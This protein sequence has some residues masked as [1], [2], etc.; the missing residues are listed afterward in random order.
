MDNKEKIRNIIN[1]AKNAFDDNEKQRWEDEGKDFIYIEMLEAHYIIGTLKSCLNMAYD[2]IENL[3][4]Q[5][6]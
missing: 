6:K 3:K 4:D 5:I 1:E 2:A